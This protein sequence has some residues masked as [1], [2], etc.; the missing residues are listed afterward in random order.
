MTCPSWLQSCFLNYTWVIVILS[1]GV[2]ENIMKIFA[3][4]DEDGKFF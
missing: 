4:L 1:K 2:N 3:L